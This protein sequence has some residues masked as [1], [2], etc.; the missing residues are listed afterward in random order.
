MAALALVNEAVRFTEPLGSTAAGVAVALVV[1][2]G[3]GAAV[4]PTV[5]FG[6]LL[7]ALAFARS[8][9]AAAN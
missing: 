7:L 2:L 5:G 9:A 6:V 3:T 8:A 4:G 1:K